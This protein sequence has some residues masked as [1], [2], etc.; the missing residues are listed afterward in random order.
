M[1]LPY[2]FVH[3][4]LKQSGY[5]EGVEYRLFLSRDVHLAKLEAHMCWLKLPKGTKRPIPQ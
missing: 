1:A 4:V 5:K 3:Q 2:F